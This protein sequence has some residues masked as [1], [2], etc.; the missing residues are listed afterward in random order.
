M[1]PAGVARASGPAGHD[2]NPPADAVAELEATSTGVEASLTDGDLSAARD[3]AV[4]LSSAEPTTEN[5]MLESEV[6]LALGDYDEAKTA[7]LDAAEAL[8][9]D[10]P[11][12]ARVDLEAELQRIDTRSRGTVDDEPESTVRAELDGRLGRGVSLPG[13]AP[14]PGPAVVDVSTPEPIIKKWYFW[15]TLAAIAASAGAI[16]GVAISSNLEHGQGGAVSLQ[17]APPTGGLVL[18]F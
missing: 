15:V 11:A 5:F 1:L 4:A 2:L 8:P 10:A 6:W 12:Q 18:R 14:A 7:I 9:D 13:T 17:P 16:A 3:A